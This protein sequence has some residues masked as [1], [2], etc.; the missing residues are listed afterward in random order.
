MGEIIE[1]MFT[2]IFINERDYYFLKSCINLMFAEILKIKDFEYS[3]TFDKKMNLIELPDDIRILISEIPK[4]N[5]KYI[6]KK[7]GKIPEIIK[8]NPGFLEEKLLIE[9]HDERI[10]LGFDINARF[11]E[12]SNYMDLIDMKDDTNNNNDIND[13]ILPF[14]Y[15]NDL[16]DFY[17]YALLYYKTKDKIKEFNFG[18]TK[19]NMAFTLFENL[20]SNALYNKNEEENY[21]C[22]KNLSIFNK[23][24]PNC[25]IIYNKIQVLSNGTKFH[26]KKRKEIPIKS[27]LKYIYQGFFDIYKLHKNF[28]CF[29]LDEYAMIIKGDLE[30]LNFEEKNDNIIFVEEN[31]ISKNKRE[32][33]DYGI[34][35]FLQCLKKRSV[36]CV[37]EHLF[38]GI[39]GKLG[40]YLISI[41]FNNINFKEE[42]L[43]LNDEIIH[44][45]SLENKNIKPLKNKN[46]F[47]F[48]L[49]GKGY[50]FLME[51]LKEQKTIEKIEEYKYNN[52]TEN[53]DSFNSSFSY[54]IKNNN[55]IFSVNN[56]MYFFNLAQFQLITII[57]FEDNC[58]FIK[59]NDQYI[60]CSSKNRKQESDFP[61][62][63][64]LNKLNINLKK[65]YI[66]LNCKSL[67][68]LIIDERYLFEKNFIYDLKEKEFQIYHEYIP[69]MDSISKMFH[70]S[71]KEFGIFYLYENKN[72]QIKSFIDFYSI[73]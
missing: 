55:L 6:C 18:E 37:D 72:E 9:C 49:I 62:L 67:P 64:N 65:D 50:I 38:L 58:P 42:K 52:N 70:I 30:N 36:I 7:C 21:I 14:K 53:Y 46:A 56:N 66:E 60:I 59:L 48:L 29:F 63:I 44:I 28:Y 20:L 51:Y 33:E 31:N 45:I 35:T 71:E 73:E 26:F 22:L 12:I 25:F 54:L 13:I 15:L 32:I 68:D 8:Y 69:K 2:S 10:E 47:Q 5:K 34:Y 4:I 61:I 24:K 17:I 39:Q 43:D 57:H 23:V 27:G 41:D 3:Y 19:N 1:K 16:T 11:E 40:N